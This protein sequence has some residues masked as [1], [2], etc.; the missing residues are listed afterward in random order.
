MNFYLQYLSS[1]HDSYDVDYNMDLIDMMSDLYEDQQDYIQS[2]L[3]DNLAD[4]SQE[5]T[6]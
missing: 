6:Q 1:V 3:D 2:S 4:H 5:I